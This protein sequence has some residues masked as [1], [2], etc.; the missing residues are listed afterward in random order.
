MEVFMP[1][2]QVTADLSTDA[3]LHAIEQL[4]E[5]ELDTFLTRVL[6]LRTRR[7][8]QRPHPTEADLLQKIHCRLASEVQARYE[9]L[10]DKRD[11]RTLSAQDH[12]E[13][14]ELTDRA[15][16]ADVQR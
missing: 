3:L 6:A 15:E 10:I 2:V 9:E 14:L 4:D 16:Q 12:A 7:R 13:L 1:T 8:G 11:A 5:Q